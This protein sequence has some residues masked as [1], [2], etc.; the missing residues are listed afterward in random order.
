MYGTDAR[1]IE[2]LCLTNP[3]LARPLHPAFPYIEAEV[4]WAVRSEMARTLTDVLARRLRALVL[5]TNASLVM[6]PRVTQ[7]VARELNYPA[8]WVADQ[9]EQL[10]RS[11]H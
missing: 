2:Q 11:T 4:I 10:K 1:H 7:L 3:E 9:L 6:A 5:N 8:A